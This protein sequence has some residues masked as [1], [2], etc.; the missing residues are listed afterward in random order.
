MHAIL[1]FGL[2]GES[3]YNALT[4]PRFVRYFL[5][6]TW[7]AKNIDEAMWAYDVKTARQPGAKNAPF[8]FLSGSLFSNDVN[9]LYDALTLPVW[10]SHGVRGDFVDFRGAEDMKDRKNWLISVFETGAF[11]QFEVPDAFFAA[12]DSFLLRG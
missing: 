8:Y 12:Y 5:E 2:W 7:G 9:T 11:P 4:L 6:R 3:L 10:L 1:S